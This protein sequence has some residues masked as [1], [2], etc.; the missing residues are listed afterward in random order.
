MELI[1]CTPHDVVIFT[2]DGDKR[3]IKASGDVARL[4]ETLWPCF[5]ENATDGIRLREVTY[6]AEIE[7]LPPAGQGKKFIVSRV[8]A[9]ASSRGDLMFPIEEVRDDLGRIIGCRG[10]GFFQ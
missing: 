2:P 3:I 7:G 10:L 9:A 4:R 5:Y 6:G 1:N 8:T